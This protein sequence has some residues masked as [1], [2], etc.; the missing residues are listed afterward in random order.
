[1]TKDEF[2]NIEL[3]DT[4][5]VYTF[6]KGAREILYI[7]KATSLRDRVRSYF[8]DDVISTRGSRI[9]DMVT[10]ADHIEYVQT[11]SVLEALLLESRLIKKHQP[12]YNVKE[13]D[14]KSFFVVVVTKEDVPKVLL[15]RQRELEKKKL[16]KEIQTRSVFGPFP[17]GS[18]IREA[19]RIVRKIFPFQDANSVKKDQAEFYKQ[20]GLSPDTTKQERQK[21]Y[22]FNIKNIEMFLSGKKREVVARLKKQMMLHAKKMEFEKA[23]FI[24]RK[25]YALEH[26]RDVSL[27]KRE[28][29]TGN[30]G[31]F[32]IESYDISHFSGKDMVG[33]MTVIENGSPVPSE[34][35]KFK[36]RGFEQANDLGAL[37]EMMKRRLGHVEWTFP[38]LIVVDGAM[39]Q[40]SRI[41]KVLRETGIRIPVVAV[42]KNEK[43]KP[44]GILGLRKFTEQYKD[45]ILLSNAEAHR[46]AVAYQ[47]KLRLKR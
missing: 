21:E 10:K 40:K 44:K 27:I 19:L 26:I 16:A 17:S 39:P 6:K 29:K 42:V 46:F 32:R 23:D 24:K 14:N 3:P 1:M 4:P 2:A 18:Q 47:K 36:I 35:R 8:S 20:I 12:D 41:E 37:E 31:L 5:G 15:M 13:K 30:A 25:I 9:V 34:Y 43:H 28:M 33:A 45:E 7:G 22:E 38:N 11:D